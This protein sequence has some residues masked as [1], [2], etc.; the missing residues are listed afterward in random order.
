MVPHGP[1]LLLG[2]GCAI[3][4]PVARRVGVTMVEAQGYRQTAGLTPLLSASLQ[5]HVHPGHGFWQIIGNKRLEAMRA[6][7]LEPTT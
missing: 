7:G 1:A 2:P 6:V 5:A 3:A 4:S